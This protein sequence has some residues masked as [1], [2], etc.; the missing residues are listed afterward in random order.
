MSASERRQ[1][2]KIVAVRLLPAEHASLRAE[3]R[4]LGLSVGQLMRETAL[5]DVGW[6]PK[7]P[8]VKP[9]WDGIKI[10]PDGYDLSGFMRRP[11]TT[12]QDNPTPSEQG[13]E[14]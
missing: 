9:Y 10:G 11:V 6:R 14:V 5:R 7:P 13:E 4:R 8:P 2:T 1:R 12:Q 3:A